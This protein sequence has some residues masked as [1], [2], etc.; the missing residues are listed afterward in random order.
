MAHLRQKQKEFYLGWKFLKSLG[1]VLPL[2]Y[3]RL[4]YATLLTIASIL[5][6][7]GYEV[8]S[9]NSGTIIG[10]FYNALLSKNEAYFWNLFW[11]A[12]LI[13]LGQSL[14]LATTSFSTWLLYLVMRRNLTIALHKLYYRRSIYY[15]LNS[16]DNAG[17]DNPDQRITQDVER[18]CST[19]AK[20]IFPYILI[21]PGVIAFYTYKTWATAGGFGVAIIYIYFIIGV[22]A[23]RII[24]SPLTKWTARVE[25]CEGDFRYKH[26][27]VRNNAEESTFYNAAEFEEYESNRFFKRLLKRQLGA[28]L[29]KYPAQCTRHKNISHK[30]LDLLNHSTDCVFTVLQ[31]FFDYYG[32]VLSYLIQIFPI[33]IFLSYKDMDGPTLA[34]QISNN[35]FYFIYLINSFTRLTDLALALGEL[36]G[37]T[38][39]IDELVRYMR[40]L[41]EEDS[42]A[43]KD[44]E[45]RSSSADLIVAENLCYSAPGDAE[46]LISDLNLKLSKNQKLLIT[47]ISGVGKSS[48][49]R[50]IRKLWEPRSGTVLRN[51]TLKDTMFIPQRPYFP[52]GQLSLRQQ[53]V[54][55]LIDGGKNSQEIDS[56]KIMKILEALRLRSLISMCG[57]LT[58]PANFEWQAIYS[59]QDTLSPGEQ[60]RLSIARVLYHKPSLVFLDEAT[61]SLSVDAEFRVYQLLNEVRN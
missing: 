19:L 32:G 1:T 61:S 28:T 21:S 57:S 23:N 45:N 2:L 49:L 40:R 11:K 53:V 54:F 47:G 3:P 17:I 46:D 6:A 30:I 24:V 9:Y 10:K 33:F 56:N 59:R 41:N 58:D 44:D 34:Q 4:E 52:P 8:V 35:A 22:I 29:W 5:C 38:Q 48:L 26:V 51:F 31:N 7:A 12:S 18:M 36:A 50:I 43:W 14:L 37:Y 20:N 27:S 42:I 25:R 15:M 60:Q 39:R 13:Y 55:P 16:V